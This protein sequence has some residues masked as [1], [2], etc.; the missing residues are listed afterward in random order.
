MN[1]EVQQKHSLVSFSEH[2]VDD[3]HELHDPLIQM[4]ILQTLEEVGVFTTIRANHRDFLRLS[5]RRQ[6]GHF[7]LER[8]QSHW[9]KIH[10]E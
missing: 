4:E 7:Q 8:L 1:N 3:G 9:L 10:T 2:V 5:F 6:N